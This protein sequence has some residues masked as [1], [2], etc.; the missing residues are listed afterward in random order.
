MNPSMLR[1]LLVVATVAVA[2]TANAYAETFTYHGSLQEAGEPANGRY[3][4]QLSLYSSASGGKRIAGPVTLYGVGVSGGA[5][6]TDVDFGPSAALAAPA[7]LEVAVKSADGTDFVTLEQ[8]SEVAPAG[9]CP[10]SWAL[11]GNAGIPSGSYLG[12]SDGRTLML[13]SAGGVGINTNQGIPGVGMSNIELAVKSTAPDQNSD[14]LLLNQNTPGF[15]GFGLVS[16]PGGF[17][18]LYGLYSDSAAGTAFRSL[19]SVHHVPLGTAAQFGFNRNVA[20]SGIDGV[21][22]VGFDGTN[23]NGAHLTGGGTWT[24]G[25]SRLFKEAFE[26]VDAGM[27]L[28]RVTKLDIST[29]QYRDGAA[30][31]RHLGPVAEDFKQA[32]GLGGNEKYISTVDADGV[33]LAAIQGLNRKMETTNAAL[34]QENAE[35]RDALE[36]LAA[37]LVRLEDPRG[38]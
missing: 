8:R 3:D 9:G 7:W 37:R 30:E 38:E 21:L 31:G 24:N 33:A 32:F 2:I 19:I 27:V 28:D 12:S 36:N 34:R 23:G 11:D 10:S 17:F 15:N 5:F 13:H 4:L 20:S 29:W 16:S 6:S 1:H 26:A 14:L 18:Q 35:L 25:S 22:Q